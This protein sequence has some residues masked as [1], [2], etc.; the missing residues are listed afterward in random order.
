MV[1]EVR[2]ARM[3]VI[4]AERAKKKG[5]EFTLSFAQY[6]RLITRKICAYS[7]LR[8]SELDENCAWKSEWLGLTL[9]RID[10][11]KGYIPGNVV[12]V[13]NGINQIKSQW[14]NPRIPIDEKMTIKIITKIA[15][16]KNKLDILD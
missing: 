10:N 4:K 7:G 11:S 9:D 3:Y 5:I 16:A 6:K 14:E 1:D 13:C 15:L 12:P 2:I 8:F